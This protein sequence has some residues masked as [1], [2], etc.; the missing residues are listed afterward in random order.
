MQ[1]KWKKIVVATA[2]FQTYDT[3]KLLST[4][5]WHVVAQIKLGEY[6][7]AAQTLSTLGDLDAPEYLRLTA[8]GI[9]PDQFIAWQSRK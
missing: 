7:A 4:A 6:I 2:D 1:G 8:Q 9:V 5:A 3:D